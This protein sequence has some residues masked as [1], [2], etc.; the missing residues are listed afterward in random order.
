[1]ATI[2]KPIPKLKLSIKT[3]IHDFIELNV[4]PTD[5][6]KILKS[7]VAKEKHFDKTQKFQLNYRGKLLSNESAK[8]ID[9]RIKD[10]S[11]ID[12]KRENIT[13]GLVLIKVNL[14]LAIILS[15]V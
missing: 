1:M 2:K 5:T 10:N 6:I 14:F 15:K 3:N 13:G 9:L 7:K 12:L 11:I 4:L 8:I